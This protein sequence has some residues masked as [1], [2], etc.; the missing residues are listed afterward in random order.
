MTTANQGQNDLRM[1]DELSEALIQRW[2]WK[3]RGTR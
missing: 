3:N 1:I 2:M